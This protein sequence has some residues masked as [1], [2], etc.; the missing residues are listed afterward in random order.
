[1]II[2]RDLRL[3]PETGRLSVDRD[4]YFDEK[5]KSDNKI[6]GKKTTDEDL[7]RYVR[8]IYRVLMTRGV[9]GTFV[10]VQD[11]ALRERFRRL[12]SSTDG[13]P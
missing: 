3:D 7:L 9:R 12:I 11:P 4:S 6:G 2:G 8:N 13:P 10:Y 5:G 1:M